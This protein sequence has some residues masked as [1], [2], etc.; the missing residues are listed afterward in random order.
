MKI[1]LISGQGADHRLFS[2]LSLDP[3]FNINY[4]HFEIPKKGSSMCD[5]GHQL[6]AQIDAT[7]PFILIGVS[8]GGMIATEINEILKPTQT[9]V[10]SS[11]KTYKELPQLYT[12]QRK[13]KIHKLIPGRFSKIAAQVLQPIFE[14][15]RKTEKEIFKQMLKDKDPIF[16]KRTI[17]MIVRW[18]RKSYDDSIISIHG[19]NDNTIPIRNV[20]V[21]HIVENGS[22][23]MILTKAN[24]LSTL[25]NKILKERNL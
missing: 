16:L 10:I 1:Y 20:S 2:K 24:E 22:H 4:I 18:D 5:Y 6:S 25:L 21:D 13:L 19:D 12:I 15:A 8:I 11:A 3:K 14:P 17:D 9:I 7:Q 23:L